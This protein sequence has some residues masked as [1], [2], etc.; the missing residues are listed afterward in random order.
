MQLDDLIEHQREALDA[1]AELNDRLNLP[2]RKSADERRNMTRLWKALM[3]HLAQL[4][5]LINARKAAMALVQAAQAEGAVNTMHD[6]RPF[7]H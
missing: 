7:R 5:D 2:G 4:R 1:L 3:V 6:S